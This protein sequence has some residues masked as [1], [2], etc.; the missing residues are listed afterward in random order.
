[1]GYSQAMN[2]PPK[3]FTVAHDTCVCRGCRGRCASSFSPYW[4]LLLPYLIAPFYGFGEPVSTVMLWRRLTGER[5]E[6]QYVPLARSRRPC[7][8]P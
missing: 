3:R 1:M 4:L 5:V 6:H 7:R 2:R 8:S